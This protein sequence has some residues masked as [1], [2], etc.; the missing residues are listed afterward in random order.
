MQAIRGGIAV[1]QSA[2]NADLVLKIEEAIK[3]RIDVGS[4][5]AAD[6]L[7]EEL[8][9]KYTNIGAIHSAVHNLRRREELDAIHDGKM[10]LRKK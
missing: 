10:L 7:M 1:G 4:R 8:E 2:G 5:V 3:R 9:A 6:R